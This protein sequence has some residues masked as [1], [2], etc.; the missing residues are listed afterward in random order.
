MV[1]IRLIVGLGNPGEEYTGTRH[2]TGF[3]A[4]LHLAKHWGVSPPS[5]HC[6]S[7]VAEGFLFKERVILAQPLTFM[8]RSGRAL[9]SLLGKYVIPFHRVLIIYDDMDL[10]LGKIR[11]RKRGG[12]GG[13]RGL[14]SIIQAIGD[15]EFP[16]LRIGIGRP[17]AGMSPQSYVLSTLTTGEEEVLEAGL[18]RMVHAV[19]MI[20]AT[21]IDEAMNSYN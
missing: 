6:H 5:T 9:E 4:I 13:H 1:V 18:D 3:R 8:N 15:D 17:P 11:I 21:G 14:R 7:L 12:D 16:R 19:E 20:I 10:E 2:N